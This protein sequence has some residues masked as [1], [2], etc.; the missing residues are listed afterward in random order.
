MSSETTNKRKD[1][2]HLQ[3]LP[4]VMFKL[5]ELNKISEIPIEFENGRWHDV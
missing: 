1:I 3:D 2:N 4:H 5:E